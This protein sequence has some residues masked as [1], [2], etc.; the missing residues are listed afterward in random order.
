MDSVIEG[1]FWNNVQKSVDP[2]GCWW[3]L[4]AVVAGGGYGSLWQ[5]GKS[6]LV[7]R[8]SWEIHNGVIPPGLWVCHHCDN[9]RCVH[10]GHLFI[11]SRSDNMKDAAH[12]NRVPRIARARAK[13][14]CPK[15]HAYSS[16]NTYVDPAGKRACKEC[17]RENLRRW[18]A[19]S[20]K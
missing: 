15:G 19:T 20:G 12:K 14:H 11:G 6:V 5:K 17:R 10:P 3:W 1:K 16:E 13:T 8:I 2:D 18:R 4:G 7:H 9:P